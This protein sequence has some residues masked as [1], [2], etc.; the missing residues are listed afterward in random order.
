MQRG[1]VSMKC[2][3]CGQVREGYDENYVDY[4]M[5]LYYEEI[6]GLFNGEWE[7]GEPEEQVIKEFNEAVEEALAGV[8]EDKLLSAE[9]RKH[10]SYV[11]EDDAWTSQY[12]ETIEA[13][14]CDSV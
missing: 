2:S 11:M 4:T 3:H 9:L 12:Q 1:G 14:E 6:G 8:V 5:W 13:W 10:S 7:N